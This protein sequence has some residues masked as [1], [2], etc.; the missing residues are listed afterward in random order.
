VAEHIPLSQ[1]ESE[2]VTRIAQAALSR[3]RV[4]LWDLTDRL[5]LYLAY[6]NLLETLDYVV[7]SSDPNRVGVVLRSNN[8]PGPTI[9]GTAEA[10]QA[11]PDWA[12]LCGESAGIADFCRLRDEFGFGP[13]Q[14]FLPVSRWG[15]RFYGFR[16]IAMSFVGQIP[17]E[18]NGGTNLDTIIYA[19]EGLKYIAENNISGD[20][21][22]FGVY[23]GWSMYY[24]ALVR[25]HFALNDKKIVG[26]DTFDGFVPSNDQRD[27][28][29]AMNGRSLETNRGVSVE[30]VSQ[31]LSKLSNFSLIK[32]D[33]TETAEF[34]KHG[35]YCMAFV[36]IDDYSPTRSGLLYMDD[37]LSPG[38]VI[39][40]DHFAY[41]TLGLRGECIGER[42]AMEDFVST[43]RYHWLNPSGTNIFY[44]CSEKSR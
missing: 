27:A 24:L 3:R 42:M 7:V 26:F 28:Y 22:N 40:H 14:I 2:I 21:V 10:R 8:G 13:R 37:H 11:S 23:L 12:I 36:D 17:P 1:D 44:K 32:G 18:V 41:G 20:I 19:Y 4:A 31:N 15:D 35:K 33:L 34:I 25:D 6:S 5:W 9:I 30:Q 43:S 16:E 38:G 29:L 39:V